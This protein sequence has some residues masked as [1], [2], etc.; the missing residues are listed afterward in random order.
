MFQKNVQIEKPEKYGM[1]CG[2]LRNSTV[3]FFEYY[4]RGWQYKA[5]DPLIK[6]R[7]VQHF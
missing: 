1:Q 5:T 3:V 2:Y 6:P 4:E 7:S